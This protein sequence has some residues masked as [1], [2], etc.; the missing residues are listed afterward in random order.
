VTDG[1]FGLVLS[2]GG[3]RGIAHVG[4]LQALGEH[5]LRPD[6]VAGTSAG[7]LVGA[8]WAAGHST[9]AMLRFFE[10]RS[11]FRLSRLS[12]RKPGFIDT[13]KVIAD[14][15][16][17]F[18]DDRFEALALPLF[19]TATDL[20]TARLRVFD[21][22]PLIQAIVASCSIP[23]LFTP[24]EIDGCA[25]I[26]GG[27]IDNFPVALLRARCRTV[28][29]V[30][31]SPLRDVGRAQIRTAFAVSQRAFEVGMY[32]RSQ[33]KF[34]DCDVFLCPEEL[35]RFAPFDTRHVREIYQ[36]GYQAGCSRIGA[37]RSALAARGELQ[38]L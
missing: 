20:V 28:V 26:D 30:Y 21:S 23:M 37:I 33:L 36:V 22:G 15:R 24:T 3:A 9:E 1:G 31:A 17:E 6:C 13:Q 27:I 34:D 38:P 5:G 18:P 8:L 12:M 14:L 29:G 32:F 19:V 4:V 11:P 2:G 10:Q 35:N 16:H 7:A 25:Y